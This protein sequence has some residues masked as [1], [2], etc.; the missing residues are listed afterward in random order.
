MSDPLFCWGVEVIAE[1]FGILEGCLEIKNNLIQ[2]KKI[3]YIKIFVDSSGKIELF[4]VVS[5]NI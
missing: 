5:L 1:L 3:K 4:R 2:K